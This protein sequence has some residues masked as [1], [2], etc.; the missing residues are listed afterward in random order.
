MTVGWNSILTLQDIL[1]D[2]N[3]LTRAMLEAA[4]VNFTDLSDFQ[5]LMYTTVSVDFKKIGEV[6]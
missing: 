6:R 5:K 1:A 3:N 2:Q 4:Q